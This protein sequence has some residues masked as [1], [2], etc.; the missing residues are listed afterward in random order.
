[1]IVFWIPTTGQTLCLHWRYKDEYRP[2]RVGLGELVGKHKCITRYWY[3]SVVNLTSRGHSTSSLH[4][5]RPI[6]RFF[7]IHIS[8][9]LIHISRYRSRSGIRQSSMILC[10]TTTLMGWLVPGCEWVKTWQTCLPTSNKILLSWEDVQV[11]KKEPKAKR[12]RS[13]LLQS[14][15]VRWKKLPGSLSRLVIHHG[16]PGFRR[17]GDRDRASNKVCTYLVSLPLSIASLGNF[18]D[19]ARLASWHKFFRLSLACVQ[20]RCLRSRLIL[21]SQIWEDFPLLWPK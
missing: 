18:L 6:P 19:R 1:M 10:W 8:V 3:N 15:P 4:P 5:T 13:G 9:D 12:P 2:C 21:E 11:I 20:D 16:S 7:K 17:L 14:P